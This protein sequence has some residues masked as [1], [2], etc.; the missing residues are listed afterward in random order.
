M[1]TQQTLILRNQHQ[2]RSDFNQMEAANAQQQQ[3]LDRVI[4]GISDLRLQFDNFHRY[5]QPPP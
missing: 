1:R 5:P 4:Y 3:Q 2:M